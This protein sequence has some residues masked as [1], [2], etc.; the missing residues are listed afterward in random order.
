MAKHKLFKCRL[1]KERAI[2]TH[3]EYTDKSDWK[4]NLNVTP[5]SRIMFKKV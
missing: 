4:Y 1:T 2:Y 3:S 5:S